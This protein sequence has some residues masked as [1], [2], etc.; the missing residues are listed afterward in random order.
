M[1]TRTTRVG[2]MVL[3]LCGCADTTILTQAP[4]PAASYSQDQLADAALYAIRQ[5]EHKLRTRGPKSFD[6]PAEAHEFFIEQR[7]SDGQPDYPWPHLAR[8]RDEILVREQAGGIAAASSAAWSWLGPG[9]RGGRTRAFAID[10]NVPD[11]MYAGGVAGGI[12]KTTDGGA[13]W[14]VAD[15]LLINLAVTS[16]ALD[17]NDTSV[18]YAGTGEGVLTGRPGVRGLGIFKSVDAG[19]TWTQLESTVDVV[20]SSA[21]HYVNEVVISPNDSNRIYAATRTGVWRSVDAGTSWSVV[22]S[23]PSYIGT[24]PTTNGCT[25]GCTDLAIRADTSPD[26]IF[27]SFGSFDADGLYRSDDG[28]DTWTA[29]SMGADQ[30]RMTVALAPSDNDIVYL[31]MANNGSTGQTGQLIDV[32]RSDDGGETFVPRVN[33]DSLTGPWLL[34]NLIL[35]TGCV[36][37][38]TYSQGWYDNIIAVDPVDPD[39]VWVGGVDIF[40]SDDGGANWGIPGYWVFYTLDPPPPYYIHPDHHNIVFHPQYDGTSNQTMYVTNDGGLFRTTNARAATSQE[41]CPLPG[42]EPLPEIVWESLNHNYGVTQFY[43]GDSARLDDVFIGGCQDNGSNRVQA[44]GAPNDWD[45]IFGGDGGYTAI[46][47]NDSNVMYVEYQGFPTI[48]KSVNGGE[49]F[50]NASATITDTDG[51]FITPIAMDQADP[52]VL[53]TGGARPWRTTNAALHWQPV[54]PN[55]AGPA[56]ISAIGIAPS[57]SNVV[58]LGFNNGYV[59]RTTQGLS[60]NPGWEIFVNGLVGAW[61]SSVAVDPQDPDTAY[62]TYSTFGVPHVLRTTNGGQNWSSIDGI[63]FEG[64]PDIPAHWVAVRP[65]NSQQLFV[66]TELGVFASD[67]GGASWAPFNTGLAHTVVETL[68]WKNENTLV[69]FT[70]GRGAFMTPLTPCGC[71]WD[72]DDDGSVGVT[73]FLE[74]LAVWGTDPGGPPDFDG[75]GDVGVNDFLT[76][77]AYWGPCPQ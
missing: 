76:L 48:Q 75:D 24:P 5:K 16:I 6:Q 10:P 74:L 20:P 7:L 65:C 45:L 12:W 77:L 42:D 56:K 51:L 27:A 46:S 4:V 66:G 57:D 50:F 37:G 67:D 60:A 22:L 53:W 28:G 2:L 11:I 36:E 25:V 30:G 34:S 15:D 21:F 38:G 18:L 64:V 3:L 72:L 1:I 23:N 31:L 73:D 68:D 63:E 71:P 35:A 55:F 17:P 49:T 70:H 47:P 40:R 33:L 54:G 13:S 43:H 58:Y 62:I 41:D 29:Y 26:V 59:A 14:N 19:A 8:A 9:N 61:V 32:F 52:D 44:V 69:A 39:I